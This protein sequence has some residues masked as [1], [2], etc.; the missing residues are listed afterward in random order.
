MILHRYRRYIAALLLCVA[1]LFAIE[2]ALAQVIPFPAAAAT[3]GIVTTAATGAVVVG[4]WIGSAA[5]IGGANVWN[6]VGWAVFGAAVIGAVLVAADGYTRLNVATRDS[7]QDPNPDYVTAPLPVQHLYYWGWGTSVPTSAASFDAVKGWWDSPAYR[8]SDYAA[9]QLPAAATLNDAALRMDQLVSCEAYG[10]CKPVSSTSPG[11]YS[12]QLAAW[13]AAGSPGLSRSATAQV[14]TVV[15]APYVVYKTQRGAYYGTFSKVYD[16]AGCPVGYAMN[17]TTS[18][19]QLAPS[20]VDG[21]CMI[22]WDA[23]TGCPVVNMFDP[24]CSKF[25]L[26]TSC[27]SA[28]VPPSV[29]GTDPATGKALEVTRPVIPGQGTP[30]SVKI[31]ELTPNPSSNT[32]EKKTTD[33]QPDANPATPPKATGSGQQV[34]PGTGGQVSATPVSKVEVTNWP[35]STT[36]GST[37][38]VTFPERMKVDGEV[39]ADASDLP[40]PPTNTPDAKTFLD[41]VKSRLASIGS[42]TLP[43]HT[44]QCPAIAVDFEAWG[45]RFSVSSN[46]MCEQLEKNKALMQALCNFLYLAAAIRI[47][48]RA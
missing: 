15:G 7:S 4:P 45:P 21:A 43:P 32:T 38:P 20:I 30:K 47:V 10:A 6:P 12:A 34:F 37:T 39:P 14:L 8:S 5:A 44:S 48:L 19:C 22:S 40:T 28:T 36:S 11:T 24:D 41:P 35:N 26:N 25:G 42:F 3:A 29:T 13:I 17:G 23:G 27:G 16:H 33:L 18:L 2:R 46:F 31:S 9:W 1:A